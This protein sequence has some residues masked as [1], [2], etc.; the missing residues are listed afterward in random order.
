MPHLTIFL[1]RLFLINYESKFDAPLKSPFYGQ[2]RIQ[3]FR[4]CE[5]L[6]L[7]GP[8]RITRNPGLF[9]FLQDHQVSASK[10]KISGPF[11]SSN[12]C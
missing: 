4:N 7:V 3:E 12:P 9:D 2:L 11:Y 6:S 8:K 5:L 1:F 10:T